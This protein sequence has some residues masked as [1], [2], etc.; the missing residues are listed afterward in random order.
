[1]EPF[2]ATTSLKTWQNGKCLGTKARVD[3]A[4]SDAL[5][6]AGIDGKDRFV[7]IPDIMRK[8]LR[9]NED[10]VGVDG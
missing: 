10:V 1:M 2:P 4:L 8:E 3:V 5:W 6:Y 7:F 9:L